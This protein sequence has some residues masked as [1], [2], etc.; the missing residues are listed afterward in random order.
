MRHITEDERALLNHVSMFGS[1]GYPIRKLKSCWIVEDWR[2]VKGAPTTYK[3]KRA[4]TAH[5]EAFIDVL[6]GALGEGSRAEAQAKG[7][8][9]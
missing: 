5:F 8:T 9:K 2:S 6:I 7:E 3:T 1:D 4:A